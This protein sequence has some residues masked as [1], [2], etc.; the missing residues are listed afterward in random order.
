MRVL[1]FDISSGGLARAVFD[2]RLAAGDV[3]ESP[4]HIEVEAD[5]SAV[6]TVE[7]LETALHGVMQAPL[8]SAIDAISVSGFMHSSLLLDGRN[9]PLTPIFTWMDRRGA[10]AV[11]RFRQEFGREFHQRT[12][13]RFHPMFPVFKAATF[14]PSGMRRIVSAKTFII[15]LLTGVWIEDH[16]TASATG[17]YNT[18]GET[19]DQRILDAVPLEASNLVD[20]GERD[21]IIGKTTDAAARYGIAPGIPLIAGSGDGFLANLGSGCEDPARVAITLGTSSSVRQVLPVPVLNDGAGTFCYRAD[22]GSYLLG[23][24]S[25]NGGNVLEW[26]RSMFGSL[27]PSATKTAALPTFIPLLNGERSPEWNPALKASWHDV[28]AHHTKEDLAAAVISGV[29]FNLAHYVEIIERSSGVPPKQFILS[30]NG[31]LNTAA[32]ETLAAVVSG[33]V[34]RPRNQGLASLRGAAVCALRGL[35]VDPSAHLERLIDDSDRISPADASA[36]R[37]RYRRYRAI[38]GCSMIP[39]RA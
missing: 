19:W 15:A 26:A 31:F 18:L 3:S 35:G 14:R 23:C 13:C 29:V 36:I 22:T 27:P 37:D 34:I 6:L 4:W 25:N 39:S 33:E 12:G 2:E 28:E 10:D 8:S 32:C 11:D 21:A 1:C 30:G 24:A 16:G 7:A 5:S 9:R 17:L 38:R 20:L